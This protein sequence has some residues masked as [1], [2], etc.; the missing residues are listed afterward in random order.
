MTSLYLRTTHGPGGSRGF[1]GVEVD[2]G[3]I[4]RY[5]AESF[6]VFNQAFE[7]TARKEISKVPEK[8]SP[9]LPSS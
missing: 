5:N 4:E 6:S 2:E 1:Q 3:R 7:L 8:N 9:K